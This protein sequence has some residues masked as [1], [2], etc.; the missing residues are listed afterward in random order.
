MFL[1]NAIKV[2]LGL[3]LVIPSLLIAD[4]YVPPSLQEWVNW[5]QEKSPSDFCPRVK[6]KPQC[7]FYGPL[8]LKFNDNKREIF[9]NLKVFAIIESEIFLPGRSGN[10][11]IKDLKIEPSKASRVV[12]AKKREMV[13]EFSYPAIKLPKGE[14]I[15][16]GVL[17]FVG[18]GE[19]NFLSLPDEISIISDYDK[20]LNAQGGLWF[21][22]FGQI[23]EEQK[24]NIDSIQLKVYRKLEDGNPLILESDIQ[25]FATGSSRE[26]NLGKALPEGVRIFK[27]DCSINC[28]FNVQGDLIVAISEGSHLIRITG[29]VLD[30]IG[31]LSVASF[32][33]TTKPKEEYWGFRPDNNLRIIEIIGP[34]SVD[35]SVI[36]APK[37][38]GAGISTYILRGDQ[39]A[40][41]IKEKMRGLKVEK[42]AQLTMT[43]RFHLDNSGEFFSVSNIL[44]GTLKN[45]DRL[46]V[47]EDM[48]LGSVFANNNRSLI[49]SGLD[50]EGIEFRHN[51][52]NLTAEG[53]VQKNN[54]PIAATGWKLPA[55]QLTVELQLPPAWK[56]IH[57]SGVDKVQ[58]SWLGSWDLLRVFLTIAVVFLSAK[59]LG[60]YPAIFIGVG[61]LLNHSHN[62]FP[63]SY[64]FS[65]LISFAILKVAKPGKFSFC[66][67]FYFFSTLILF[68]IT[69]LPYATQEIR[70]FLYPG[71]FPEG[72]FY[73]GVYQENV[74]RQKSTHSRRREVEYAAAPAPDVLMRQESMA[75]D[76]RET[77]D[78]ANYAHSDFLP[79]ESISHKDDLDNGFNQLS[80]TTLLQIG[81]G[82][83][84]R[85]A[86]S[87]NLSWS[88]RVSENESFQLYLT[89][90]LVNRCF[91]LFRVAFFAFF[92]ISFFDIKRKKLKLS[93]LYIGLISTVFSLLVAT[94]GV[95]DDFPSNQLLAE[96]KERLIKGQCLEEC[97]TIDQLELNLEKTGKANLVITLSARAHNSLVALPGPLSE[98]VFHSL[99]DAQGKD[100]VSLTD[101]DGTVWVLNPLGLQR[102]KAS[103]FLRRDNN[104]SLA[105]KSFPKEILLKSDHFEFTPIRNEASQEIVSLQISRRVVDNIEGGDQN[106]I[107]ITTTT[108]NWF[109]V[110]KRIQVDSTW[111]TETL[112]RRFG[113]LS[114]NAS[115]SFQPIEGEKILSGAVYNT[116]AKAYDVS[117]DVG[118]MEKVIM[119]TMTESPKLILTAPSDYSLS[120]ILNCSTLFACNYQGLAPVELYVGGQKNFRFEPRAGERL[121]FFFNRPQ[122]TEGNHNLITSAA[123]ELVEG[124]RAIAG[125]LSYDI[126]AAAPF[127]QRLVA[128]T[129]AEVKSIL[130]NG[131]ETNAERA[132]GTLEIPIT[133][134]NSS[135]KILLDLNLNSALLKK[136]SGF[137]L[138]VEAIDLRVNFKPLSRYWT[139]YLYGP[140]FGPVVLFWAKLIILAFGALLLSKIVF[141]PLGF[142]SWFIFGLGIANLST[143]AILLV[144]GWFVALNFRLKI[145][146]D[147]VWTFNFYQIFLV[148]LTLIFLGVLYAA[149]Q[150]GLLFSPDMLIVGNGSSNYFYSW[151]VDRSTHGDIPTVGIVSISMFFWRLVMLIWSLWV[152]GALVRW[153]KWA[154]DIFTQGGAWR[155]RSKIAA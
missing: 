33:A 57:A 15:I 3:L 11:W 44:N 13:G 122:A 52:L 148:F 106:K 51:N 125:T 149:V 54:V 82:V 35:P 37:S 99:V 127:K 69:F 59:I 62:E 68:F 4:P 87:Y 112:I 76:L 83:P 55:D 12:F 128:P 20:R 63:F 36:A 152:I 38:W 134:N 32:A 61:L 2:A 49:T 137:N 28:Y 42:S 126:L 109:H 5:V 135:V 155:R 110:T 98:V 1:Q 18:F 103:G 70:S 41:T 17:Q 132:N 7:V 60:K 75:K 150:N 25:L 16:S 88:G 154:F 95:A 58:G 147:M 86:S 56:L 53:I 80:S 21:S 84:T 29:V 139:L 105:F 31:Q 114:T 116:T 120:I 9:F 47:A 97:A 124:E 39:A 65:L 140:T 27:V 142:C 101:E 92:I 141:S 30:P 100:L 40:L 117:F 74:Y 146:A 115:F 6:D 85:F 43:R 64:W 118:E 144:I 22:E 94:N 34:I 66:V 113:S 129:G 91:S 45:Y 151:Y 81:R 130:V 79:A 72:N 19:P 26:L 89:P 93:S 145:K 73:S 96:L 67:R 77:E 8:G 10:F 23:K 131:I 48:K 14:H 104:I 71:L 90:P 78:A 143:L 107:S 123:L 153:F 138:G 50:G 108:P 111:R 119:G 133:A 46:T 24:Q 102:I 121:S 136:I